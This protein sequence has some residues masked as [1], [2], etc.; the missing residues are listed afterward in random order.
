MKNWISYEDIYKENKKRGTST[1]IGSFFYFF[2]IG[3]SYNWGVVS[4]YYSSYILQ[5]SLNKNAFTLIKL[6]VSFQFFFQYLAMSLES[7]TIKLPLNTKQFLLI[8]L[9]TTIISYMILVLFGN[10]FVFFLVMMLTGF[11]N[12]LVYL[13]ILKNVW[14]YFPS[15]YKGQITGMIMAGLGLSSFILNPVSHYIINPTKLGYDFDKYYL[16][17]IPDRTKNYVI[18]LFFFFATLGLIGYFLI[19]N[20]EIQNMNLPQSKSMHTLQISKGYNPDNYQSFIEILY[21]KTFIEMALIIF[22]L[23]FFTIFLSIS[24][25]SYARVKYVDEFYVQLASLGFPFING[26]GRMIWG[27]LLDKSSYRAILRV[28]FLLQIITIVVILFVNSEIIIFLMIL[29]GAVCLSGLMGTMPVIFNKVF[30][31]KYGAEVFG[32]GNLMVGF[33]SMMGS[34]LV[35]FIDISGVFFLGGILVILGWLV[36]IVFSR[37][38]REKEKQREN[39]ND[40]DLEED[41][42]DEEEKDKE[43]LD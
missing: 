4:D 28:I 17:S 42:L 15:K 38:Q 7:V 8:S 19:Y 33:S 43:K 2:L 14:Q 34:T 25:P 30:G 16:F 20:N 23:S 13:K 32:V 10:I 11:S 26:F 1:L 5:K 40:N 35:G 29:L 41:L 21:T 36:F 9:T 6:G 31:I 12:G 39:D 37:E 22:C 24:F 3:S 18:F 27:M